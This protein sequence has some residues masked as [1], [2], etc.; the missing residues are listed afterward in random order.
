MAAVGADRVTA[1]VVD[2]RDRDGLTRTVEELP[3]PP[4]RLLR[5]APGTANRSRALAPLAETEMPWNPPKEF[6]G[7]G[8][9]G[10]LYSKPVRNGAVMHL[11]N[12]CSPTARD[13]KISPPARAAERAAAVGAAAAARIGA[14]G[15]R[16]PGD[17]GLLSTK[18]SA[19]AA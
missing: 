2:D 14:T 8:L 3:G 19:G 9:P 7:P 1:V 4:E 16:V 5:A 12:T 11:K 13:V 15:V 17:P 6:R 10:E 18:V